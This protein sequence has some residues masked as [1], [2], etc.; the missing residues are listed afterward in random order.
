M[1]QKEIDEKIKQH[2][3]AIALL[4]NAAAEKIAK[5]LQ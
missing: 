4:A 1:N 3:K 5:G 2:Q